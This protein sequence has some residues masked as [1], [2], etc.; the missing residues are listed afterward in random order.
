MKDNYC[1]RNIFLFEIITVPPKKNNKLTENA[2]NFL[3]G[4]ASNHIIQIIIDR[5]TKK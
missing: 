5:P 3:W 1:I 4:T 2:N